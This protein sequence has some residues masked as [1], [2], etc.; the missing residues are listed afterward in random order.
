MVGNE[1]RLLRIF[2]IGPNLTTWWSLLVI[3]TA[4]ISFKK[5]FER[6]TMQSCF[7]GYLRETSLHGFKYLQLRSE[8][9]IKLL[10]V[11]NL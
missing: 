7:E 5:P 1:N 11:D 3:C 10:W 2:F 6:G 9:N 8:K 4:F